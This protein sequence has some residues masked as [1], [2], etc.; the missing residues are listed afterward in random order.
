M[1]CSS[2]KKKSIHVFTLLCIKN[3]LFSHFFFSFFHS[4]SFLLF[5]LNYHFLCPAP[6]SPITLIPFI[7]FFFLPP[8]NHSRYFISQ[9]SLSK[10]NHNQN[11]NSNHNLKT[12][13][14]R[15]IKKKKIKKKT[16][17]KS[18]PSE[19]ISVCVCV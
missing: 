6:T 10:P 4:F 19:P 18:D 2:D 14:I 16:A 5:S 17:N 11:T 1:H 12:N 3:I 7:F 9:T 15:M 8:L 13:Q